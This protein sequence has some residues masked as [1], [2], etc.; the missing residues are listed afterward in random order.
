MIATVIF[1]LFIV[2]FYTYSPNLIT[3][4]QDDYDQLVM[5][6]K[7][8]SYSLLSEGIPPNW[9][10]ETKLRG[11]I[12]F[13]LTE[14]GTISQDKIEDF[15][16]WNLTATGD[17]LRHKLHTTNYYWIQ[18]KDNQGVGIDVGG[19]NH[20][21]YYDPAKATKAAKISRIVPYFNSNLIEMVVIV[22]Y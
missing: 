17:E 6:A 2:M 1:A 14:N 7:S 5:E 9:T 22:W 11:I 19:T 16:M 13:G 21:G 18:F 3:K 10:D 8:I 20:S 4:D 15:F 12:R